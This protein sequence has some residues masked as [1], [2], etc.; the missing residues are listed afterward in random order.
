MLNSTDKILNLCYPDGKHVKKIFDVEY[1]VKCLADEIRSE[2]KEPK[3]YL[4]SYS[5]EMN[6]SAKVGSYSLKGTIEVSLTKKQTANV[7]SESVP[8][9][10]KLP[11]L[12]VIKC[13][14]SV[15]PMMP[16]S[17]IKNSLEK[18]YCLTDIELG[19]SVASYNL[20]DDETYGNRFDI[21]HPLF[22]RAKKEVGSSK[23]P[24]SITFH[25]LI[26]EI[27]REYP[28]VANCSS[29]DFGYKDSDSIFMMSSSEVLALISKLIE[30]TEEKDKKGEINTE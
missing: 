6:E 23:F 24:C 3:V 4:Y 16:L 2:L 30:S 19:E 9:Y 11:F 20:K 12:R 10:I 5:E 8:V 27:A 21:N 14:F 15:Y 25:Q 26:M 17:A 18:L 1:S 22:V 13:D 7:L 29:E 28:D